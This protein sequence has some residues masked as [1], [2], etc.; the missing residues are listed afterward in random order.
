MLFKRVQ[1]YQLVDW[2]IMKSE[3]EEDVVWWRHI[4]GVDIK[5]AADVGLFRVLEWDGMKVLR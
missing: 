5:K 3:T 4:V 2:F 1:E